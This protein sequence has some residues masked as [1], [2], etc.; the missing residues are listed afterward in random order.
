M[1]VAIPYW[2]GRVSPVF[3]V[4]GRVLLAEVAEGKEQERQDLAMKGGQPRERANLLREQGAT[5][6][7]CGAIS[8]PMERAMTAAGIEVISQTCGEIER[9]LA[10]FIGGQLNQGTFLMPGCCGRRRWSQGGRGGG[11]CRRRGQRGGDENA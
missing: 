10:A 11:R 3:D 6:L 8:R 7:I 9:V 4:A 5:V 2:Q 1:K